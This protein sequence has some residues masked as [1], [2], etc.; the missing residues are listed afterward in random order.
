MYVDVYP[1]ARK[2]QEK[3]LDVENSSLKAV[4]DLHFYRGSLKINR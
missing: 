3:N 4:G 1:S 2:S